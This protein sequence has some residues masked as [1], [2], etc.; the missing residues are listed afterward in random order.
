MRDSFS[1]LIFEKAWEKKGTQSK[2][3]LGSGTINSEMFICK[4]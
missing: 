3:R 4:G 1:N 2:F